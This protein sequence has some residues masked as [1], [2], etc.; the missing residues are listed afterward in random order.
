MDFSEDQIVRY[1]R[2]I[3][4]PEIG[5][6]GQAGMAAAK[7]LIVGA[8]GLG[9]PVGFYLT[10][11]GVG[12]IGI[13]DSDRVELSNL[14][15]QIAHRTDSIGM[16]KVESARRMYEALNPE[17]RIIP[18]GIR[19][20]VHNIATLMEEYDLVI[21]GSDN[22]Q[23]R[24]LINDACF[25]AR[26]PLVSGAVLGFEGQVWT[27]MPGGGPCYRC[28]FEHPPKPGLVPTCREAGVLGV[29][30]GVI[31]SLQAAEALKL[32]LGCG[33]PLRGT[34]LVYDALKA[35]FRKVPVARNPQCRLC[36]DSPVI[37]DLAEN[38]GDYCAAG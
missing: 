21:D 7:V 32:I 4:L 24:F 15:R 18:I 9:S 37:K 13:V 19:L 11:A 3:V 31:G 34:V 30:P 20:T 12:T 17:V 6:R 26:R 22:F 38:E 2:Q 8:G 27:I 10:A 25:L 35:S 1:S 16:P 28:L 14:H 5:G 29:V 33:E 23:T 36:G